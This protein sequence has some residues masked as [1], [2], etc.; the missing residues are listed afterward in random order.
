[1]A[2]QVGELLKSKNQQYL[3]QKE[4]Q[5][6]L[7]SHQRGWDIP[8]PPPGR[9]QFDGISAGPEAFVEA[10][11]NTLAQARVQGGEIRYPNFLTKK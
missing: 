3:I 9:K 11:Q 4:A 8:K 6:I 2:S 7:I 10:K 5:A 1:M